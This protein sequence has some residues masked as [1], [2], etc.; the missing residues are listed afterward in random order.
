MAR[1]FD[2][3]ASEYLEISQAVV[4]VHP[5]TIACW[6]RS[7]DITV[8]QILM[9]IHS[10]DYPGADFWSLA[11]SG[12]ASGDPVSAISGVS[13]TAFSTAE[14][15]TGYSANTWHHACGVFSANNSRAAYIDGGSKGTNS[16]ARNV[17]GVDTTNIGAFN[18]TG[19]GTFSA[20]SGRI[21]EA[22]IWNAALTDAE[23]AVLAAGYSPL[24][25]RPQNLIAYWPLIREEDQDRVGGYNLTAYNT[26]GVSNH[27]RIFYPNKVEVVE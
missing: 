18:I 2:D 8:G 17:S 23:V 5:L 24:F 6:F 14:T 11:C 9:A 10:D 1:L 7:D 3:A 4:S 25:V 20:M 13:L 19:V 12:D 21:A 27:P 16:I 22:G 15:T 26:P